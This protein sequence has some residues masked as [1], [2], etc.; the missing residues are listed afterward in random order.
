MSKKKD[1]IKI[2]VLMFFLAII[3][4]SVASNTHALGVAP[5]RT[6]FKSEQG[7]K[8]G[9]I[10]ILNN[11]HRDMKLAVYV[12]GENSDSVQLDKE[13]IEFNKDES[14]KEVNFKVNIP[15]DLG[16]GR[17]ETSIV[18]T[19]LPSQFDNVDD[20]LMKTDSIIATTSVASLILIDVPFPGKY[21][22]T[23]LSVNAGNSDEQ[24]TFA[25]SLFGKGEQDIDNVDAT[26]IIK[27]PTNEEIARVKTGSTSLKSGEDSKIVAQWNAG[28][29][30]GLYY[31]DAII[32]YD[33]KQSSASE[34]FLIGDKTL[35]IRN[36]FIDKFTLGKIAK[37][38]V[39]AESVWNNEI[40]DVYAEID[41]FDNRVEAIEN[42]KT[43]TVDIPAYGDAIL[44][45]YWDTQGMAIGDY[46]FNVKLY[47]EKK[48]TEKLFVAIIN[49]DNIQ[50]SDTIGIVGKA[51][52]VDKKGEGFGLVGI[53]IIAVVA[54]IIINLVW[55]FYF[56]KFRKK[57]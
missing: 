35:K 44:T 5:A 6:L 47:Y 24:T 53:L 25:I 41:V 49:I 13:L 19:E 18:I 27:G 42:I 38:E 3:L 12:A 8:D 28:V 15:K 56:K 33:G 10:R 57:K 21:I 45:G 34:V 39:F 32:Y 11:Q 30:S 17:H 50:I 37:V 36:I 43:A 16:P 55:L 14:S 54:L 7:S 48:T 23:R 22:Q 26:I 31:A 29:N 52:G 40:K 51:T 4:L 2:F 20:M 1:I 46:D 9:T